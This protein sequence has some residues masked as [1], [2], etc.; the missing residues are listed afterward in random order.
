LL[1]DLEEMLQETELI[2]NEF[3]TKVEIDFGRRNVRV[4]EQSPG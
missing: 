2:A 3:Q 1:F 4:P